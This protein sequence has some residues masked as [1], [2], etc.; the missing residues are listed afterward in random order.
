MSTIS[1]K[2]WEKFQHYSDRDPTWIKLYRDVLT[3]E[4]WVLGTDISRLLQIAI[5]LLAARYKNSI[6]N[7][8]DLI[9]KVASLDFSEPQFKKALK[10]LSDENFLEIQCLEHS[11]STA[12][13]QRYARE[14]ESRG[15][16]RREDERREDK[17]MSSKLDPVDQVFEHWKSTWK[18]P[19]SALD[20]KRSATIKRALKGYSVADLCEAI[21]G[22][23]NSRHHCGLNDRNTV[24]DGIDLLLRDSDHIDAGLRFSREPPELSSKLTQHNVAVLKDFVPSEF[25]NAP[26]GFEQ[27]SSDDGSPERD[28]RKR[29]LA[30]PH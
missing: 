6:P 25:R 10:H 29:T 13:A 12:L 28:I 20:L 3:T 5:T 11:A 22:Y 7:H 18:H 15:E 2:N 27:V 1:I 30:A 24:Y 26:T 21:S 23:L 9:K 17:D 19:R 8:F 4:A 14:D 16:E